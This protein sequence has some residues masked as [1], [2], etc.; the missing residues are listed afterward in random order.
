[1]KNSEGINGINQEEDEGDNEPNGMKEK[2]KKK[3]NGNGCKEKMK[4]KVTQ[5]AK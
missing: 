2:C 4:G 5:K 3:K 1:M